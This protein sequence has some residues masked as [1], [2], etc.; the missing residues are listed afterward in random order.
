MRVGGV[1]SLLQTRRAENLRS[2]REH[3]ALRFAETAAP[4]LSAPALLLGSFL[5]I[6]IETT[7][8]SACHHIKPP[9]GLFFSFLLQARRARSDRRERRKA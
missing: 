7:D 4:P 2:E 5:L 6:I 1:G 3:D 8:R 9:Q